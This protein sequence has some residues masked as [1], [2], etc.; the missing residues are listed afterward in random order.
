MEAILST[1]WILWVTFTAVA[2]GSVWFFLWQMTT[3][4]R[5]YRQSTNTDQ[6]QVAVITCLKGFDPDQTPSFLRSLCRQEYANYRLIFAFEDDQEPALAWIRTHLLDS[7]PA[8]D[9][10][11]PLSCSVVVAGLTIS[12]GQKVHNQL[13]AFESLVDEDQIIAFADG[14]IECSTDWLT[15]LTSPITKDRFHLASGGRLPVP[16]DGSLPTL[17]ATTLLTSVVTLPS[18]DCLNITWGGSMAISREAFDKVDVP[19]ILSGCLNDDVRLAS[20]ARRKGFPVGRRLSLMVASPISHTWPSF[21]EFSTR[22]YY[23]IKKYSLV[24]FLLAIYPTIL[25]T[26]AFFSACVAVAFGSKNALIALLLAV[27]FDQLR[28]IGRRRI[29]AAC[30]DRKHLTFSWQMILMQHAMTP[31]WMAIHAC[32]ILKAIPQSSMTWGG[33]TYQ[34]IRQNDIRILHDPRRE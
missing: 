34:V 11:G 33:I 25:C 12:H 20:V 29:F 24:T 16:M 15:M 32:V 23:Q 21:W 30:V 18:F 1:I 26:V 22:Q 5:K 31:F 28:A 6:P 14:D 10:S 4:D 3:Q 13:A 19:S 17:T 9:S 2:A 27:G 8:K 7:V